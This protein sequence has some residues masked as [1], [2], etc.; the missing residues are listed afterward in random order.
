MAL[1]VIIS[2]LA[3]FLLASLTTHTSAQSGLKITF[4]Q[5][6]AY[7]VQFQGKDNM[8]LPDSKFNGK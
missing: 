3:L 4:G 8:R 1:Q 6:K 5:P 2:A 7:D